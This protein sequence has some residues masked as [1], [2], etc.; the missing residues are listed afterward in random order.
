MALRKYSVDLALCFVVIIWSVSP[1]LFKI[2]L[3]ELDP[4]AF[5]Y[6]RFLL[7]T[8]LALLLLWRHGRR[9]GRAWRFERR[10]I[11]PLVVSGLTGYGIYQ[12]FYFV[13]LSLTTAFGSI[14][15]TATVPLFS[16]ILLALF[17]TERVSLVQWSG[18]LLAFAGVAFFL[19]AAGGNLQHE[20][21]DRHVTPTTMILGDLLTLVAALSF[22]FYGITNKK[23]GTRFSQAELMCYTLV[24]GTLA[25][26]PVGVP[27]L[28]HQHWSLVTWR[29]WAVVGY[30][31][32]FPVYVSYSI[33][34]WAII[35]RGVGYVT[36]YNYPTP[37][38][39]GAV[40]FLLLGEGFSA[41]QLLGAAVVLAG[42]LLARRGIASEAKKEQAAAANGPSESL[43]AVVVGAPA[44]EKQ[45]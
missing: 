26:A 39:G 17:R 31:V 21:V 43:E 40:A 6:A 32:V 1:A 24:V 34:N 12:L 10:D 30:G 28:F 42:L 9:G 19:L 13:G 11:L 36:L 27:A 45:Q 4:F 25:L 20:G 41:G 8:A 38:L 23:L 35:R 44:Q 22:A 7:I 37:V 14:L 2:A 15:L 3:E 33:W 5:V 29:S 16:V 18:V